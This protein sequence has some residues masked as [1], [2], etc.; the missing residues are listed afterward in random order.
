MLRNSFNENRSLC[1][2]WSTCFTTSVQSGRGSSKQCM[3]LLSDNRMW[4]QKWIRA[5]QGLRVP[6]DMTFL[7]V[8]RCHTIYTC[9]YCQ[10][11]KDIAS[12]SSQHLEQNSKSQWSSYS[13]GLL[14]GKLKGSNCIIPIWQNESYVKNL[15]ITTIK[16]TNK[17]NFE[18][19]VIH[20]YKLYCTIERLQLLFI[21][22]WNLNI[23]VPPTWLQHANA[24][25]RNGFQPYTVEV[26]VQAIYIN[27]NKYRLLLVPI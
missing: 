4:R 6:A 11:W 1:W 12:H 14:L 17:I 7:L 23:H 15:N 18:R 20:G 8:E 10:L 24:R 13:I 2:I 9:L 3:D 26:I 5:L 16:Y 27:L 21:F 25:K 22:M 19:C